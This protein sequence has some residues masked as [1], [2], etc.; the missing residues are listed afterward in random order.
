MLLETL[1][2]KGTSDKLLDEIGEEDSADRVAVVSVWM[3]IKPVS[4]LTLTV[5]NKVCEARDVITDE[6]DENTLLDVLFMKLEVEMIEVVLEKEGITLNVES[7]GGGGGGG[8]EGSGGNDDGDLEAE[9][10]E[11]DPGGLF[12]LRLREKDD[13]ILGFV[14]LED[15]NVRINEDARDA[16][17]DGVELLE[18]DTNMELEIVKLVLGDIVSGLDVEYVSLEIDGNSELDAV[19]DLLVIVSEDQDALLGTVKELGRLVRETDRLKEDPEGPVGAEEIKP[20][21]VVNADVSRVDEVGNS[22]VAL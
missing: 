13:A 3:L 16:A 5:G 7:G 1:E 4:E 17:E 19:P 18:G 22:K 11:L 20:I 14:S 2:D 12:V 6:P 10:S 15:D 8:G 9:S 21:V